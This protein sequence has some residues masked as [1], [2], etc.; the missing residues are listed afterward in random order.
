MKS[1]LL[2]HISLGHPVY[3][4]SAAGYPADSGNAAAAG[5]LWFIRQEVKVNDEALVGRPRAGKTCRLSRNEI[6]LLVFV[7]FAL[8]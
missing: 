3:R 7:C 1:A 5:L 6:P 4:F 8:M 2:N